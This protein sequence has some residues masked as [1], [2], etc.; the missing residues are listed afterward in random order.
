MW[1]YLAGMIAEI[2]LR[3]CA[4][5]ECINEWLSN[6]EKTNKIVS[7]VFRLRKSTFSDWNLYSVT[8]C[9]FSLLYHT[10][11]IN[12]LISYVKIRIYL[13]VL[14][15]TA[16]LCRKNNSANLW[17]STQW[18]Q[19]FGQSCQKHNRKHIALFPT[20]DVYICS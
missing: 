8:T 10:F 16:H 17:F 12:T 14:K 9:H 5:I 13:D 15:T 3:D 2:L 19:P 20:I 7:W 11:Y 18:A 4:C 6:H 1:R